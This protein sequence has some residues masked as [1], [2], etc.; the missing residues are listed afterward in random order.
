[1]Q[2]AQTSG[3]RRR[4]IGRYTLALVN[5]LA[6]FGE[7]DGL[8][9]G[10]NAAL[11]PPEQFPC[12]VPGGRTDLWA[13]PIGALPR[14]RF[15]RGFYDLQHAVND[16]L[17]RFSVGNSQCRHVLVTS[18]MET[19]E[20]DFILPSNLQFAEGTKSYAI[21]YDI[22]PH[23]F[24][25]VY[26]PNRELR[27]KYYAHLRVKLS[28]D[29]LFA[30]SEHTKADVVRE[31]GVNPARVV[32]IGG[33]I[34]PAIAEGPRPDRR[35]FQE[36]LGLDRPFLLFLGG[37][38]Y[39]KNLAGLV[40]AFPRTDTAI[41]ETFQ[42]LVCGNVSEPARKAISAELA[43][44]GARPDAF[45]FQRF[46][47]DEALRAAYDYSA[48]CVVPSIY[49]GFGL[50]VLEAMAHGTPVV[51]SGQTSMA[52][53]LTD[54]RFLFDPD[55]PQDMA[56]KI[57]FAIAN[58]GLMDELRSSYQETVAAFTWRRVAETVT[59]T[60]KAQAA[61]S[62]D[63]LGGMA[64][65]RNRAVSVVVLGHPEPHWTALINDLSQ[66]AAVAV[67][68]DVAEPSD[69]VHFAA[70]VLDVGQLRSPAETDPPVLVFASDRA[71]LVRYVRRHGVARQVYVL[72]PSLATSAGSA[73][74]SPARGDAPGT[75]ATLGDRARAWAVRREHRTL[76]RLFAEG[77]VEI[78][79]AR[80]PP[81]SGLVPLEMGLDPWRARAASDRRLL[82]HYR[83]ACDR[84]ANADRLAVAK[85]L[86]R[87]LDQAG[88]PSAI[89]R[90]VAE[91]LATSI[92]DGRKL[93]PM[94]DADADAAVAAVAATASPTW[95]PAPVVPAVRRASQPERS[96]MRHRDPSA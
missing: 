58:P 89:R 79:E 49:E 3:S 21:L 92:L 32:V 41:H 29:I 52:E 9:L 88:S 28:A 95:R 50:P 18:V 65:L 55:D 80:P 75:R 85:R 19:D 10:W 35:Q 51:A 93:A 4:G 84:L 81:P 82:D 83:L 59:D 64:I 68:T 71:A 27:S 16:T 62:A 94:D 56:D 43:A 48:L 78:D 54:R 61:R 17:F 90:H 24:P 57:T 20:P 40:K 77:A 30:I 31:F 67:H 69:A 34:D 14:E 87:L 23:L 26:L 15:A 53:I 45:V 6:E 25:D 5:A 33:G 42:V 60:I 11:P 96:L 2:G 70:R 39:R 38:E 7:L 46:L 12:P 63:L 47:S 22:I 72:S 37:D 74:S 1:M 13:T 36:T 76:E 66:H 91:A 86:R 8:T 73:G 44:A